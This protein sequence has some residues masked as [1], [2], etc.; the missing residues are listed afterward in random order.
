MITSRFPAISYT[1]IPAS[2]TARPN[3]VP[4][5]MEFFICFHLQ[6]GFL[7]TIREIDKNNLFKFP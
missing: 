1:S 5:P 4:H 3:A 7:S 6:T 2:R